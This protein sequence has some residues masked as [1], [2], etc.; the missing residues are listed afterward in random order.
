MEPK[1]NC[2]KKLRLH[3]KQDPW[4]LPGSIQA[5][6]QAVAKYVDGQLTSART[7]ASTD[8]GGAAREIVPVLQRENKWFC[9]YVHTCAC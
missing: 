6:T 1:V 8:R 5:L 7:N 2:A 4:N 3:V 9:D